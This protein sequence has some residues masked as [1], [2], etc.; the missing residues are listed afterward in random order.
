M[1][2]Q[3]DDADE[4]VVV[5]VPVAQQILQQEVSKYGNNTG[6]THMPAVATK[7]GGLFPAYGQDRYT[8]V[9]PTEMAT[10]EFRGLGMCPF[11]VYHPLFLHSSMERASIIFCL[12]VQLCAIFS[13][14]DLKCVVRFDDAPL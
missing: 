8:P 13:T 3:F 4:E 10:A 1:P 5:R 9:L 7:Q 2:S 12:C 6:E 14:R 11:A